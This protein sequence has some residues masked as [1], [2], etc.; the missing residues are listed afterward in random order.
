MS[1]LL[2]FWR[3]NGDSESSDTYREVTHGQ[4]G[5]HAKQGCTGATYL[6][7]RV[8]T[9]A[10]LADSGPT[11][12][13][14]AYSSDGAGLPASKV[15]DRG[16]GYC[17]SSDCGTFDLL[18]AGCVC[19]CGAASGARCSSSNGDDVRQEGRGRWGVPCARTTAAFEAV[20]V[21]SSLALHGVFSW[22]HSA[23]RAIVTACNCRTLLSWSG[24]SGLVCRLYC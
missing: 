16:L 4:A 15:S 2:A 1:A 9:P 18:T 7:E 10:M 24:E 22:I 19:D 21:H 20:L 11:G 17:E 13:W 23:T 14:E 8:S 5:T 6:V 3:A 12:P